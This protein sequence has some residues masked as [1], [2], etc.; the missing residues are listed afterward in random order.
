M[1]PSRTPRIA[2]E[3]ARKAIAA[4]MAARSCLGVDGMDRWD[5]AAR[6]RKGGRR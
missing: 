6:E 5:A 1:S 4:R 2:I 3:D